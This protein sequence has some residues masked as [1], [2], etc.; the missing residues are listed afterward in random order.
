MTADRKYRGAVVIAAPSVMGSWGLEL[1]RDAAAALDLPLQ[2]RILDRLDAVDL[3]AA[4]QVVYA[5]QFP[6]ESVLAVLKDGR[7]PIVAFIDDATEAIA[8]LRR[9]TGCTFIDAL[10]STTCG[11]VL[12]PSLFRGVSTL[13]LHRRVTMSAD[14]VL[15]GA[16]GHLGLRP[17]ARKLADLKNKYCA[18]KPDSNGIEASLAQCVVGYKPLG[19]WDNELSD[20]EH[21]IAEQALGPLVSMSLSDDRPPV[22]WPSG[23]F[24][25]GDRPNERAPI[26]AEMMGAARIIYYGPYLYLPSGYWE[27]EL[28]VGFSE[29]AIGSTFT[30]E[31]CGSALM[32]RARFRAAQTGLFRG[33]FIFVHSKLQDPIELR[34]RNDRGAIEGKF[35]LAWVKLFYRDEPSR[36]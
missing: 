9:T 31:V 2:V 35:G 23:L 15:E 7:L 25:S 27:G 5:T 12:N 19:S 32:A 20:E 29:D 1:V 21:S 3:A 6:S 33:T 28:V 8:Y 30:V 34:F 16:L 22:T 26:V 17:P 11:A 24:L 18:T 36:L 13:V 10:R 14:R 4:P